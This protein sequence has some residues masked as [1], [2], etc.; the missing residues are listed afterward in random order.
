MFIREVKKVNGEFANEP[1][2]TYPNIGQYWPHTEQQF[3][4]YQHTYND[5]KDKMTDC[6]WLLAKK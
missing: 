1:I 6:A 5:S 2:A 3:D 4:Q